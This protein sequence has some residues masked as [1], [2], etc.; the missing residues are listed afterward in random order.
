MREVQKFNAIWKS[1]KWLT[2]NDRDSQKT[3]SSSQE[4]DR[5]FKAREWLYRASGQLKIRATSG[6]PSGDL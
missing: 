6:I 5:T 4:N 1:G 2:K 3:N